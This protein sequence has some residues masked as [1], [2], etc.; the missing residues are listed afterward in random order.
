MKLLGHL[1]SFSVLSGFFA[2]IA[3]AYEGPLMAVVFSF[4]IL[5]LLVTV[6]GSRVLTLTKGEDLP[7]GRWTRCLVGRWSERYR[8]A[9][10]FARNMLDV[11]SSGRQQR[12]QD[13]QGGAT[14][15]HRPLGWVETEETALG[16]QR[17][18]H[19]CPRIS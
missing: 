4:G 16:G 6:I 8:V 3:F 14:Q 15:Q 13:D 19:W 18:E 9:S 17:C 7:A 12:H 10:E 5:I 2:L 1:L 11:I